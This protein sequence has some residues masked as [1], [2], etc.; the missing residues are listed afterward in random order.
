MWSVNSLNSQ[1]ISVFQDLRH[2]LLLRTGYAGANKNRNTTVFDISAPG[3][4]LLEGQF[5]LFFSFANAIS[6]VEI[7]K[8][9][10]F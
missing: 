7:T 1:N 10:H 6:N 2:L 8:N 5:V 9:S 3:V 4:V